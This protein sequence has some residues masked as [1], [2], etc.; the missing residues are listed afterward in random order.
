MNPTKVLTFQI[1]RKSEYFDLYSAGLT[2]KIY[3]RYKVRLEEGLDH[4]LIVD[5]V[6]V[7]EKSKLEKFLAKIAMKS[8]RK[9]AEIKPGDISVPW[10]ERLERATGKLKARWR[11]AIMDG[12]SWH[13]T[14]T[15]RPE[16]TH[17]CRA[18]STGLDMLNRL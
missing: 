13:G 5:G 14:T 4:I 6:P 3:D 1:L 12:Y 15:L 10:N 18:A 9:G 11:T 16:Y 8:T 2:K 7:I 17:R